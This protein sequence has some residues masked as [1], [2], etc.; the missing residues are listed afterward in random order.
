MQTVQTQKAPSSLEHLLVH[1]MSGEIADP[2]WE[3]IMETF[4][5]EGVTSFERMAFARFM[6]EV[7][8]EGKGRELNVPKPEEL[9]ELLG[10]IRA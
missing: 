8:A 1:Y 2:S 6:S 9:D 4:D 7:V 3:R 10:E 5:H